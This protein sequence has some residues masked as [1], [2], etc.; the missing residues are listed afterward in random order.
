MKFTKLL[1]SK[2]TRGSFNNSEEPLYY[3]K[4]NTLNNIDHFFVLN[5]VNYL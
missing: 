2:T 4:K 5:N 3:V 1:F